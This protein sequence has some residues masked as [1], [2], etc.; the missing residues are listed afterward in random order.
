MGFMFPT[1]MCDSI[2]RKTKAHPLF[3]PH[4]PY[5]NGGETVAS[6]ESCVS[7]TWGTSLGDG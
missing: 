4:S 3:A 6:S 2:T 7:S 5:S 1:E